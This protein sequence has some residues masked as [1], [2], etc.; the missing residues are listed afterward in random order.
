MAGGVAKVQNVRG[1][2]GGNTLVGNAVGNILIGGI[3]VDSL[4]AGSGRSIL[5]GGKGSDALTGGSSDD[6]LIGGSTKYDP[7]SAANDAALESILD[8]WQSND[9]VAVRHSEIS[10]GGNGKN[11][12]NTLFFGTSVTDDGLSNTINSGAGTDWFF[13]HTIADC[14]DFKKDPNTGD[15][16]NNLPNIGQT[17]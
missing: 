1:G 6:I 5:I 3:G 7:S 16:F 17:K 2:S 8:E 12:K 9:P 11:G 10:G 13:A 14:K 15:Y 4:T